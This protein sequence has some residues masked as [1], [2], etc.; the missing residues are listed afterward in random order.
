[1]LRFLVCFTFSTTSPSQ[2]SI[3]LTYTALSANRPGYL[4]FYNTPSLEAFVLASG[5]QITMQGNSGVQ[6]PRQQYLGFKEL[7]VSGR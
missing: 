6:D 1:V 3:S 2:N 4:D 5:V 7:T